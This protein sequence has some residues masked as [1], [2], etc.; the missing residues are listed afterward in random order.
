MTEARFRER[1]DVFGPEVPNN[2]ASGAFLDKVLEN[3]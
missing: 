1:G 2:L 3:A